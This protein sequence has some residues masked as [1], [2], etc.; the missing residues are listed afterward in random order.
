MKSFMKK[1][2]LQ[3]IIIAIVV[4][5]ILSNF[6]MPTI[7]KAEDVDMDEVGGVLF[8]P[9]QYLLL[10]IG[11]TLLWV[12]NTCAYGEEVDPIITLSES[13]SAFSITNIALSIIT[14]RYM[15]CRYG[16]GNSNRIF[17]F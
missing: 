17:R 12:A 4:V 2:F 3:K 11:D 9:I 13:W 1:G 8:S 16:N 14:R 15:V 5:I 6:I 7:S 10:G